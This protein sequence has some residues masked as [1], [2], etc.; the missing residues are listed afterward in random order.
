MS[1]KVLLSQPIVFVPETTQ[2]T[3]ASGRVSVP[4]SVSTL[5]SAIPVSRSSAIALSSP[6]GGTAASAVKASGPSSSFAPS[7]SANMPKS[8]GKRGYEASS[9]VPKKRGYETIAQSRPHG[10]LPSVKRRKVSADVEVA[11]KVYPVPM[12]RA[13]GFWNGSGTHCYRNASIQILGHVPAFRDKIR[14][15]FCRRE[16]CP[17]CALRGAFRDHFSRNGQKLPAHE[18]EELQTL[19]QSVGLDDEDWLE[20]EDAQEYLSL[21]L[22]RL[23]QE[24]DPEC[25][26]NGAISKVFGATKT[27]DVKCAKCGHV[28]TTFTSGEWV[29]LLG[30]AHLGPP[31]RGSRTSLEDLLAE[32]TSEEFVEY[33][34]GSCGHKGDA[35]KTEKFV[36]PPKAALLCLKRFTPTKGKDN[37]AVSFPERLSWRSYTKSEYGASELVAVLCH[38][39][40]NNSSGHYICY[41]RSDD[42]DWFEYDD[43][44]VSKCKGP[45]LKKEKEA[46]IL[47]YS[48]L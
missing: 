40:A 9:S 26:L 43:N 41:L 29:N 24:S 48:R 13:R 20:Q 5:L 21:L 1:L 44:R 17:A 12:A 31:R 14:R 46:Y 6:Q 28:S 7:T 30:M 19:G 23:G 33:K 22:W 38:I 37:R 16:G 39:S 32:T 4:E 18:P 36:A 42:G 34:C 8:T 47:L 35:G 27:T 45:P 15:H 10:G 25:A 2:T 11:I 3:H